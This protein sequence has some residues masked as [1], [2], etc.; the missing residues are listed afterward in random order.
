MDWTAY[1]NQQLLGM[2]AEL[3][4][5]LRTRGVVRSSN[6]PVADFT[7][8]LVAKALAL[9]VCGNSNSGY[10]AIGPDGIRYQIKGR[11]VTPQN[12]S[13]ELSAIRKLKENPFDVLVAVLFNPDFTV[14]YAAAIPIE[15]VIRL[16]TFV[17]HTNSHK[18]LFRPSVLEEP[19]V[20]DLT[21]QIRA[22]I[23]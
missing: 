5:T 11:R 18:F 22:A 6:N 19:T 15:T 20:Q 16:S 13:T 2:Y 21:L 1:S 12:P 3:M 23:S 14:K 7:E 8:G 9:K 17:A 4:D 10:D